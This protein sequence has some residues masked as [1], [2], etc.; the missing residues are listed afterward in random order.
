MPAS[1]QGDGGHT[2][3]GVHWVER[4]QTEQADGSQCNRRD[5][6]RL[7][8]QIRSNRSAESALGAS[9]PD[10][11]V[12]RG[13]EE[14]GS[15]PRFGVVGSWPDDSVPDVVELRCAGRS[16]PGRREPVGC[17][18]DHSG[19]GEGEGQGAE[20]NESNRPEAEVRGVS[21]TFLKADV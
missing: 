13:G 15:L 1:F 19:R 21:A 18:R 10:P 5:F 11:M 3:L 2:L 6:R 8:R 14:A 16:G 7:H 4:R 20:S 17:G 12:C 9:R